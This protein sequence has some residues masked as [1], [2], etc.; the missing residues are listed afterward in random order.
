MNRMLQNS[1]FFFSSL[2]LFREIM[3]EFIFIFFLRGYFHNNEKQKYLCIKQRLPTLWKRVQHRRVW[4]VIQIA[5]TF[6]PVSI[7]P[8]LDYRCM[9]HISLSKPFT[10]HP[11]CH[12]H[13]PFSTE[14]LTWQCYLEVIC[15]FF[16]LMVWGFLP[17]TPPLFF[18]FSEIRPVK[19]HE[20]TPISSCK[21]KS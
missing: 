1:T 13:L 3:K 21:F 7:L 15:Y 4:S 19:F 11:Y 8:W 12:L 10:T 6:T 5:K 9:S 16:F 2:N 18:L 17:H 20:A 14:M